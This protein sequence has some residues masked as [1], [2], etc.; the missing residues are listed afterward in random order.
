MYVCD[1]GLAGGPMG[2]KLSDD[3]AAGGAARV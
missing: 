1:G 3:G 2:M